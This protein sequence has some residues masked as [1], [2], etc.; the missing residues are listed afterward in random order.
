I[1]TQLGETIY[2]ETVYCS[3]EKLAKQINLKN[4]LS[5]IYLIKLSTETKEIATKLII[6]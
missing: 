4:L 2:T 3:S 5:G 6:K 1:Y